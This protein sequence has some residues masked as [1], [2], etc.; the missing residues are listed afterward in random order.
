MK[1][2]R[3]KLINIIKEEVNRVE[4]EANMPQNCPGEDENAPFELNKK[5]EFLEFSME[6]IRRAAAEELELD[7]KMQ[8]FVSEAAWLLDQVAD[9]LT[10]NELVKKHVGGG[11]GEQQE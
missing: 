2:T 8:Y 5:V 7:E 4:K 10:F 11:P 1:F 3:D 9:A 6:K